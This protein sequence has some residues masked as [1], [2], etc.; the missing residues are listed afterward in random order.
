[1]ILHGEYG[2]P[3]MPHP[4]RSLVVEVDLSQ[5]NFFRIERMKVDAE[6]VVLGSDGDFSSLKIFDRLI[7][8]SVTEFQLKRLSSKGQSQELVPQANSEDRFFPDQLAN[9]F[10]CIRQPL[11]VPWAIG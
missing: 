9:G 2:K 5:F 6:P 8:T 4:F 11:R 3:L 7:C 1:M 10:N